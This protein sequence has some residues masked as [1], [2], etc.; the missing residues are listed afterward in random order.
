MRHPLNT[1]R[2]TSGYW[3]AVLGAAG[4]IFSL[5]QSWYSFRIPDA[6][7]EQARQLAPQFGAFGSLIAK[8][9]QF[10]QQLGTLHATA[11]QVYHVT[12]A[13][14]L[15][16]GAVTGGLAVLAITEHAEAV[17][18]VIAGAAMIAAAIVLYRLISPAGADGLLHPAWGIELAL[19]SATLAL[20]GGLLSAAGERARTATAT[21]WTPPQPG[22]APP[23][24]WNPY[25][26]R[27]PSDP[28]A[29]DAHYLS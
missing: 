7:V 27:S 20:V 1:E 9:A 10:A 14:L 24:A 25:E 19:G 28:D 5:W 18:Q 22:W 12:P 17:G 21:T 26:T 6:V 8:G 4:L 29:P 13:I 23:A 16:L 15:L 2:R 11:W 3:L